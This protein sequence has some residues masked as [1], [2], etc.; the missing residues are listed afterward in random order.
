[1]GYYLVVG[2]AGY[3]GSRL[4]RRLLSQ[5]H[6]V[7][8]VVLNPD[9]EEVQRLA[10]EGMVVW[11]GD[12]TR[13]E[14]LIGVA[15]GIDYVYN[16]AARS[17]LANGMLWKTFVEGNNNLIAACSRARRVRAYVFTSNVAPYGDAG[18]TLIDED[19]PVVP[20]CP[21]G[22]VM[23]EAEQAVMELVRQHNFPAMILRVGKIY[24]PER[25]FTDAVLN[26]TLTIFGSGK[27][28]VSHIHID[29]LLTVLERV[30]IDGQPGAVYNVADDEPARLADLYGEIRQRLGM[31]PPRT[32]SPARALAAGLDPNVVG[33]A[34]ASVRLSNARLKHDLGIALRY[35]SYRT[36]LDEQMHGA[37]QKVVGMVRVAET[38]QVAVI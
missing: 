14:T 21:L 35:P 37:Q 20:A 17:V 25:D 29:D 24:G 23:V 26:H 6:S 1:M 34:S 12:I 15:D 7:R 13:P 30:V 16:L 32:Y 33:M 5:G 31:L 27:N 2:A 22:H 38:Q 11:T 19:T 10:A 4:V 9:E 28:F 36:W 8:G 18:E 3:V